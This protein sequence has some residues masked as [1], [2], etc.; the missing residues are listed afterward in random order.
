MGCYVDMTN[1]FP[2]GTRVQLRLS[3]GQQNF[4]TAAQVCFSQIGLGMGLVFYG[5]TLEQKSGVL[6]IEWL[7]GGE[8][9]PFPVAEQPDTISEAVDSTG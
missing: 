2:S 5:L 3:R 6:E 9:E 4:E 8:A 7:N 1:P